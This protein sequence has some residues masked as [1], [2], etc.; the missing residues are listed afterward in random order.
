MRQSIGISAS[1]SRGIELKLEIKQMLA[2]EGP[3]ESRAD[4]F[5][6][7]SNSDGTLAL[8]KMFTPKWQHNKEIYAAVQGEDNLVDCIIEHYQE[9]RKRFDNARIVEL[10]Q[11]EPFRRVKRFEIGKA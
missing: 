6:Y 11:K 4:R 8:Y 7:A 2:L 9:N 1:Q 3:P 5:M 10:Y